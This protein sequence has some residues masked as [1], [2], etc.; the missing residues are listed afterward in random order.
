MDTWDN[1]TEEAK[2]FVSKILVADPAKRMTITEMKTHPWMNKVLMNDDKLE[3]VKTKLFKYVSIRKEK[4]QNFKK[5]IPVEDD[6][7]MYDDK[8]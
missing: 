3:K 2:D 6:H 5:N 7:D 8:K 1:V 4:S